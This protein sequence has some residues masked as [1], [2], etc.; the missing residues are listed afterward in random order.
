[1]KSSKRFFRSHPAKS[2]RKSRL[3]RVVSFIIP[4][5]EM[6][7]VQQ[8]SIVEGTVT[9]FIETLQVLVNMAYQE[10][11]RCPVHQVHQ[12]DTIVD[13]RSSL[14]PGKGRGKEP[15]NLYVLFF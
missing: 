7:K 5:E 11:V 6:E 4:R 14:P 1:M 15:G 8:V 13:D 12:A 9:K 3:Q 2:L 10:L